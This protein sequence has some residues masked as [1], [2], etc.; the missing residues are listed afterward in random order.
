MRQPRHMRDFPRAHTH[1][2][3]RTYAGRVH[4]KSEKG[5][6]AF[7]TRHT[8]RFALR[9]RYA[10]VLATLYATH[11]HTQPQTVLCVF[12]ACVCVC[13]VRLTNRY[14][15]SSP[16]KHAIRNGRSPV[17]NPNGPRVTRWKC[18][19]VCAALIFAIQFETHELVN[20]YY[21]NN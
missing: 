12:R 19:T 2:H 11:A 9:T 18:L 20:C 16:H 21:R 4:G 8:V 14:R 13:V 7:L 3:R 15:H 1:T 10:T 17:A 6:R 5:E